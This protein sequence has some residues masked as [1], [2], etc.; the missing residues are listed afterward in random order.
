MRFY[1]VHYT[2]DCGSS[3]GYDWFTC[4]R[5]AEQEAR[6]WRRDNPDETTAIR[7]V[8]VSPT[9]AGILRALNLYGSH[10]DNG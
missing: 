2:T 5:K 3:A 4:R 10:C 8:E 6:A 7:A 9:R 1:R